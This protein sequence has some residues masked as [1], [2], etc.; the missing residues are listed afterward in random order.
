MKVTNFT[1]NERAAIANFHP[2]ST[3]IMRKSALQMLLL[4]H[5]RPAL[6]KG[7][8]YKIKSTHIGVGVYEVTGDF[9]WRGV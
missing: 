7:E 4:N 9:N 3:Y 2:T 5:P 8:E 1:T 6:W